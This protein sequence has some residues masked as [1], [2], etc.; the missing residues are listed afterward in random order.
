MREQNV[1]THGSKNP[2]TLP[3]SESS[4]AA[5]IAVVSLIVL[6]VCVFR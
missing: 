6:L 5:V 3:E 1:T 4:L 2:Q